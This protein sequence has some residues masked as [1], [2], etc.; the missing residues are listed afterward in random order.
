MF[1]KQVNTWIGPEI[2]Q[3]YVVLGNLS[4]HRATDVRRLL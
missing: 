1:R 3:I 2:E 4:T